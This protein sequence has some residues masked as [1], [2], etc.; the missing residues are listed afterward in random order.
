MPS[1]NSQ[2]VQPLALHPGNA[3]ARQLL[4]ELLSA[5]PGREDADRAAENTGALR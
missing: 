1:A 4:S 5:L 2:G 3:D